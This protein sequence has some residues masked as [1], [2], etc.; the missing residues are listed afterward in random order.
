VV[1]KKLG[2]ILIDRGA[3]TAAE[4]ET[5]LRN[6][7]MLGGHLGT[8]L[9]ELGF[10]DEQKLGDALATAMRVPYANPE[11]FCGV[12]HAALQSLPKRIVEEYQAV[13][14]RRKDR[15]LDVAM[16]NPRDLSVL[17]A[18]SFASECRI[19]PWVAPEVRIFEAMEQLYDIPRRLRYI[20]MSRL[21]TPLS[22][23]VARD[24]ERQ[25]RTTEPEPSP[26]PEAHGAA[27]DAS[28]HGVEYGVGRSW[29][30]VAEEMAARN[31]SLDASA[32][33]GVGDHLASQLCLADDKDAIARAVLE[34]AL[35]TMKR[36]VLFVVRDEQ[37]T[38]W[39]GAGFEAELDPSDFGAVGVRGLALLDHLLG[40]DHYHGPLGDSEAH[41][42]IYT[43]L[44]VP[45]PVEILIVPIHVNDRLVA[46]FLGDGGP[47][48]RVEGDPR[49]G[50]RLAR[51]LGLALNMIILKKKIRNLE[52]FGAHSS[53]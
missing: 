24:A 15:V 19:A 32:E 17:D 48:G 35:R 45:P 18:L 31:P 13:P 37:V 16:I 7:L 9:L 39:K 21:V 27:S 52:S 38:L 30:E 41:R 4:L 33:R 46:L 29:I 53:S 11:V 23:A 51:M 5:A 43:R 47:A 44:D 40:N 42:E 22:A 3:I 6:Q 1:S 12:H 8:C 28:D 49:E 36:A 34:H 26:A 10:V 50:L 20:V 25:E 14:F 2:E